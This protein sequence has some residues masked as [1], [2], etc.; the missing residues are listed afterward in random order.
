MHVRCQ[1]TVHTPLG[2][3]L[4]ILRS[5]LS[6]SQSCPM[7]QGQ[8]LGCLEPHSCGRGRGGEPVA[9]PGRRPVQ[10]RKGPEADPSRW[11]QSWAEQRPAPEAQGEGPVASRGPGSALRTG[12]GAPRARGEGCL[13]K[14]PPL[15]RQPFWSCA[16][17]LGAGGSVRAAWTLHTI[18]AASVCCGWLLPKA[19][20]C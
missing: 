7:T 8:V 6:L 12:R 10:R 17:G 20:K 11:A 1:D 3:A 19:P 15:Y 5:L 16:Q 4:L 18:H 2:V 13:L 9:T 14:N